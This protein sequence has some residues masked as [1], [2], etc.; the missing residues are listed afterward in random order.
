MKDIGLGILDAYTVIIVLI[1][2]VLSQ[3]LFG[4]QIPLDTTN[5]VQLFISV[6]MFTGYIYAMRSLLR[7]PVAM[8]RAILSNGNIND[9]IKVLNPFNIKSLHSILYWLL[10]WLEAIL[11]FPIFVIWLLFLISDFAEDKYFNVGQSIK[12]RTLTDT[13]WIRI[14]LDLLDRLGV[15]LATCIAVLPQF[16][17]IVIKVGIFGIIFMVLVYIFKGNFSALITDELVKRK[18]QKLIESNEQLDEKIEDQKEGQVLRWGSIPVN[19]S[20]CLICEKIC[21]EGW[22][23]KTPI[24]CSLTCF[25]KWSIQW[26]KD[27][28]IGDGEERILLNELRGNGYLNISSS[29]KV[30]NKLQGIG[31][32]YALWTLIAIIRDCSAKTET[33][34]NIIRDTTRMA[35]KGIEHFINN[36]TFAIDIMNLCFFDETPEVIA[37]V[38]EAVS[39]C[40]NEDKYKIRNDFQVAELLKTDNLSVRFSAIKIFEKT[41]NTSSLLKH[42]G[43]GMELR[44]KTPEEDIRIIE[45]LSNM[46]PEKA[47]SA[48]KSAQANKV[49][50][51]RSEATKIL[52]NKF[53]VNSPEPEFAEDKIRCIRC[54]Y[55]FLVNIPKDRDILV[56]KSLWWLLLS[57]RS[58]RKLVKCPSCRKNLVLDYTKN[59]LKER[60]RR[61]IQSQINSREA[62]YL[63]EE[64][65][66]DTTPPV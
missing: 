18:Q 50:W 13:P 14:L 5:T 28:C 38:A 60:N 37:A 46:E 59:V 54:G 43:N 21:S 47:I 53:N 7:L 55:K 17:E 39:K 6:V 40:N 12:V 57:S 27:W 44:W 32:E 34:M 9:F 3:V 30:I 48:L 65:E 58:S 66:L 64:S 42:L 61:L 33:S 52:I 31:S 35:Q 2:L 11:F 16:Q 45:V 1:T 4:Y 56:H 49:S 23:V 36:K 62:P 51:I 41:G 10:F 8:I 19:I 20:R 24:L 15:I 63:T 22:S 26:D 29:E 25:Q